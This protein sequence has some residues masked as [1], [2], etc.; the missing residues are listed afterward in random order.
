MKN[1]NI[2]NTTVL[3]IDSTVGNDYTLCLCENLHNEGTKVILVTPEDRKFYNKPDYDVKFWM[4]SKK[5][6]KSKFLKIFKYFS[7]QFKILHYAILNKKSV[8]HYQFFRSRMDTIGFFVL[9]VF[10]KRLVHTAHNILPHE[11][12]KIDYFLNNLVYKSAE[13]II[14]HS[15]SIKRKFL[16]NFKKDENKVFVVPHGN[17]DFFVDANSDKEINNREVLNLNSNDKVMLFFG[18]VREYKG[19]NMLLDAFEIAANNVNGLKLLIAGSTASDEIRDEYV[20]KILSLKHGDKISHKFEFIPIKEVPIYFKAADVVLLPYKEIDH[21]G[22]IHLA[23]SFGKPVIATRVG[24]FEEVIK[25]NKS[26]FILDTNDVD[27]LAKW[28]E[29]AFSDTSKLKEM[30][31]Y[32]LDLS[33]S[34]YSWKNVVA[35]TNEVYKKIDE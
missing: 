17:F 23:Y 1:K 6:N 19:L 18:I 34:K 16:D 4:P 22:I 24:D 3:M 14:V 32:C 30:G 12:M 28:I 11:Q 25:H 31:D 21:S 13:A 26:G 15:F 8:I 7:Y 29:I 27:D 9:R 20:E 2:Q 10:H 35:K 33:E 5:Q